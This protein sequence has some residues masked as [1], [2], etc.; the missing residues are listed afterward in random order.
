[1]VLADF[2]SSASVAVPL[3]MGVLKLAKGCKL[4]VSPPIFW[5][6]PL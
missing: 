2:A 1:M 3:V 5:P 4:A 6:M